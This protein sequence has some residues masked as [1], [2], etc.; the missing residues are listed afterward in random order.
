MGRRRE[1]RGLVGDIGRRLAGPRSSGSL[2]TAL[3]VGLSSGMAP[4]CSM[5]PGSFVGCRGAGD[6]IGVAPKV[7]LFFYQMLVRS[8]RRHYRADVRALLFQG[9]RTWPSER[10]RES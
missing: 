3:R 10:I 6:Y 2:G 9:T 4:R 1:T 8:A 7:L 5:R